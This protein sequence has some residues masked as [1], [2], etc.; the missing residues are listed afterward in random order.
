MGLLSWTF[1]TASPR[2]D[3]LHSPS[4]YQVKPITVS[5]PSKSQHHRADTNAQHQTATADNNGS[6]NKDKTTTAK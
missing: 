1:S 4:E 3:A 5:F 2:K 6:N